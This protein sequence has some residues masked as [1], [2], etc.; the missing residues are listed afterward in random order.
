MILVYLF[1]FSLLHC[2]KQEQTQSRSAEGEQ[3]SL[4]ES[5]GQSAGNNEKQLPNTGANLLPIVQDSLHEVSEAVPAPFGFIHKDSIKHYSKAFVREAYFKDGYRGESQEDFSI[6][7][8]DRVH[9]EFFL[10]LPDRNLIFARHWWYG[11]IDTPTGVVTFWQPKGDS[12]QFISLA[13]KPYL[14]FYGYGGPWIA[15]SM[16]YAGGALVLVLNGGSG[17][18]GDVWGYYDVLQFVKNK[19]IKHWAHEDYDYTN[20]FDTEVDSTEPAY[21]TLKCEIVREEKIAFKVR[22]IRDTFANMRDDKDRLIKSDTSY[23]TFH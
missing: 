15:D 12:L 16:S 8:D 5:Q 6:N 17:D 14:A 1:C 11:S 2:T 21:T 19:P 4:T 7:F 18:A 22:Y 9:H 10:N 3:K 20:A 13:G 23:A